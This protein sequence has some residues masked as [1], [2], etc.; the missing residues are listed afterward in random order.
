MKIDNLKLRTKTLMPLIMMAL[1]VLAMVA[2]GANRLSSVSETASEIIEHRDLAAVTLVRASRSM[3]LTPVFRVRRPSMKMTAPEG[4]AADKGFPK[5]ISATESLLDEAIKLLPYKAGG[6]RQIQRSFLALVEKAKAP[7]KIGDDYARIVDGSKLKAEEL[8]QMAGGV[9]LVAEVDTQMRALVDD[10]VMFDTAFLAENAKA[11]SDLRTQ[12]SNALITM[13]VVGLVAT[14]LAGAFALW[15]SSSK[16]ARPLARLSERMNA[17]ARGDL[18]VVIDGQD[19]LDEVGDMAKAVQI[20]KGNAVERVRL[21]ADSRLNA[22]PPRRSATEPRPKRN[23]R[24]K[25][26]PTRCAGSAKASR[27]SPAAISGSVSTTTS[28]RNMRKSRPTST[29]RSTS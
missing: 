21:E 3:V 10:I 11:A 2:F 19:R 8:D 28:R 7:M 25:N 12:S 23:A 13:S 1:T 9:K 26:R 22:P 15:I 20:F 18:T 16:I 27:A 5:A 29:R 6:N 4:R 24:P 14:L 17:L